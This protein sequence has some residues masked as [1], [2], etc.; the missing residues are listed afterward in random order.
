MADS[1]GAVASI[2]STLYSRLTFSSV[3]TISFSFGARRKSEKLGFIWNNGM[4]AFSLTDDEE[5]F[6]SVQ[7]AKRARTRMA[8]ILLL[9]NNEVRALSTHENSFS[10]D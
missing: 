1:A 5:D 6:N 10:G 4:S 9:Q 8:P 3:L 7:G 2:D